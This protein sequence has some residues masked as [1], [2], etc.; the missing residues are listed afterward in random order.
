[1]NCS[2]CNSEIKFGRGIMFVKDNGLIYYF[3]SSKCKKYF[4]MGRDNK[5]LKWARKN[6]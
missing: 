1:M 6:K 3:C 2:F 4:F 5:K